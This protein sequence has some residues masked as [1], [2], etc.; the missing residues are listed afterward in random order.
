MSEKVTTLADIFSKTLLQEV[1]G[2]S[3]EVRAWANIIKSVVDAEYKKYWD[4]YQSRL[5]K[6]NYSSYYNR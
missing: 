3:F 4:D 2:I 1:R 5:P 6:F